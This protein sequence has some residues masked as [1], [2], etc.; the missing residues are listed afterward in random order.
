[1]TRAKLGCKV[2][3]EATQIRASPASPA[4]PTSTASLP[5]TA[6]PLSTS[7]VLPVGPPSKP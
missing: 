1:M 7:K 2:I 5:P 6:L 3:R 4:P